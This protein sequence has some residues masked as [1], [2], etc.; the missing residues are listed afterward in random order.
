MRKS[1]TM[2]PIRPSHGITPFHLI[3]PGS[4]PMR[5][6]M[7]ATSAEPPST[8][9][10]GELIARERNQLNPYIARNAGSRKA[11]RPKTCSVRSEMNAPTTPIQLCAGRPATGLAA[12]FNDGSSGEYETS[13][14]TR[15]I[16]KTK[17]RKPI[18]SLSRRLVVG[19]NGR[20]RF[21]LAFDR[22]EEE[23]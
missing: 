2:R 18:S 15:R 9:A 12:V 17:I 5:P 20:A 22:F 11:D 7:K 1:A 16:A 4:N 6:A 3:G 21:I 13:A 14:R 19:V 10:H 8:F 23:R